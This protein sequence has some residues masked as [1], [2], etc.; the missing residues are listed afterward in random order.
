MKF[1]YAIDVLKQRIRQIKPYL[2][3]PDTVMAISELNQ[4]IKILKES[5]EK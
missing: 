2:N 1:E 5:K 3:N 4:A